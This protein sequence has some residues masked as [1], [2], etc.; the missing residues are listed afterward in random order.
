VI[1][2]VKMRW[3]QPTKTCVRRSVDEETRRPSGR[4]TMGERNALGR[5]FKQKR[6]GAAIRR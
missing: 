4:Q 6:K 3:G 2:H 1:E 5:T